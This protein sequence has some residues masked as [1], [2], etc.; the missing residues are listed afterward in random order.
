MQTPLFKSVFPTVKGFPGDASG[1]ELACQFRGCKKTWVQFLSWE[2]PLE[3]DMANHPS[4]LA[5]R[6]PTDRGAWRATGHSIAKSQTRLKQLSTHIK[7]GFPGG[8]SGK[9]STCQCGRHKR[10]RFDSWAGKIPCSRQ[11]QSTPVS[12][13]GKFHRQRSLVGHSLWGHKE[14]NTSEHR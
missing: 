8:A 6:I 10:H 12:L 13:P 14:S 1:K 4:T 9:E 3:K 5:W 7:G 2:D 11:W